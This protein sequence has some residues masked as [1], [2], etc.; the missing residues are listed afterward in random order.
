MLSNKE[1][2][3]KYKKY[4][5]V[6]TTNVQK[7]NKNMHINSYLAIIQIYK[8]KM[9]NCTNLFDFY[10]TYGSLKFL[11]SHTNDSIKAITTE[12]YQNSE[13]NYEYRNKVY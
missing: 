7:S 13:I 1:S 11:L 3:P 9:N 4:S 12:F 8:L 6:R 2:K 5:V 10:Y